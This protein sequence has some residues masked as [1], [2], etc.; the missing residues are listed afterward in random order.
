VLAMADA[1]TLCN[2][3]DGVARWLAEHCLAEG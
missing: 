3:E 1:V 2:D